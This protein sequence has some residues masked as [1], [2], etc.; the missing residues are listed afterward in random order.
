[1]K[2]ALMVVSML[3]LTIFLVFAYQNIYN[4]YSIEYRILMAL[5]KMSET[6]LPNPT[7]G[8]SGD[9]ISSLVNALDSDRLVERE[10]GF[11]NYLKQKLEEPPMM[12]EYPTGIG[13]EGRLLA[14]PQVL[15]SMNEETTNL[16]WV[17]GNHGRKSALAIG[18]DMYFGELVFGSVDIDMLKDFDSYRFHGFESNVGGNWDA[19]KPYKA[20]ASI[21]TGL[22][23]FEL[24]RD[25]IYYSKGKTGSVGL[26]DNFI[27]SNFAKIS[28]T[29]YPL[30]YDLTLLA[31]DSNLETYNDDGNTL[32]AKETSLSKYDFNSP[33]Q[34]LFI[35][36]MS[37]TPFNFMNVSVYE[38]MLVYGV[39]AFQDPRAL[40]PF[41]ILHNLMTYDNGNAN[42]YFGIELDVIPSKG[43]EFHIEAMFDQIQLK[44]EPQ[45]EDDSQLSPNAYGILA[46]VS[47]STI[48]K[49]GILEM[50]LEGAYV[51]PA[52]YL[53]E[54][55]G[56]NKFDVA[57]KYDYHDIDLVVGSS[58]GMDSV[59]YSYLGYK[60]GCDT[61]AVGVGSNWFDL[62]GL[63]FGFDALFTAHGSHGIDYRG[64]GSQ[65]S[66]IL[67]GKEHYNDV[68]PTSNV[69]KGL[70]PEYR[71]NL[72]ASASVPVCIGLDFSGTLA[73]VNVWNRFNRQG[74]SFTDFQLSIAFKADVFRLM[75]MMCR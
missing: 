34:Y 62:S 70:V 14:Q 57:G 50:Y 67:T 39:G 4:A 12:L 25:R 45:G 48:Y 7:S 56:C 17:I 40:N 11:L 66:H 72:L 31:Y 53:R 8:I 18:A 21:G 22:F 74:A 44:G 65:I 51:S 27:F 28:A 75:Q 59:N 23:N 60:H 33:S 49:S 10:A 13:L 64:D 1:M 42:N 3:V 6:E 69:E 9:Q 5:S 58:M 43:L 16:D 26:G 41:M 37:Y 30:S 20:F 63:E 36:R 55:K 68:A 29:S 24:G 19:Y 38:G 54:N 35:H 73:F 61:I 47:Y 46:N 32:S 52:M 2:K 15:A 71:L